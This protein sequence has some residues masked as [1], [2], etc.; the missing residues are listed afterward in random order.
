MSYA[1]IATLAPEYGLYSSF[2]GVCIYAIFATSKDITIGPVAVMSLQVARAIQHVQD[3]TDE[4][5]G[6]VIASCLALICGCIC[7]GIGVLRLGWLVEYV[8]VLTLRLSILLTVECPQIHPSSRC[9][10]IHD[11]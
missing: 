4:Y 3:R 9:F 8:P 11:W 5:T 7:L 10:R 2:V 1:K 6:P